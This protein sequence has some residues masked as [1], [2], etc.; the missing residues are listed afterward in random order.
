MECEARAELTAGNDDPTNL[1]VDPNKTSKFRIDSKS[2]FLTFPKCLLTK[3]EALNLLKLK[4]IKAKK[5]LRG[6]VV[7]EELHE[8]GTPH[9]HCFLLL[10]DRFNCVN[11]RFWD[12]GDY[13]GNYQ[14]ARCIDDVVKY[15]KKDG[16]IIEE[17]LISWKEK[18]DARK[19]HRKA[20]GKE[21]IDGSKTLAQAVNED[22]SLLFGLRHLKQDLD[23]YRQVNNTAFEADGVRGIWIYGAPRVGKSRAVRMKESDL[24]LKA[25]NKWFDGYLGQKAILIDDFDHMGK[26]LSH[27]IKIWA[28]RYA[29]TG[30]VKGSQIPL[31]HERFY[32]T[33]NYHP[34]DIFTEDEVLLEAIVSRFTII[35]M[36][37]GVE[38]LLDGYDLA[39]AQPVLKRTKRIY[40]L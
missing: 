30:E 39:M 2:W 8:D 29:C 26:C 22:P 32:V 31:C 4:L 15:I 27:Y 25:Q 34:K 1:V 38:D 24:Y 12:L 19:D 3:E 6:A 36:V 23:T 20:L 37:N 21:L 11:P 40:E 14:K 16:N 35:H 17:G 28:D 9:I 18:V 5:A 7:A 10:Q 13:H 33:S